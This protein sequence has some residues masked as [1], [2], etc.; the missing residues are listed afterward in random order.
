MFPQKLL[1][2]VF[3]REQINHG[4]N[5]VLLC[6]P[7]NQSLS[8]KDPAEYLKWIVQQPEGPTEKELRARVKSHLVPYEAIMSQGDLAE[9]VREVHSAAGDDGG[10]AHQG[11]VQGLSEVL[12]D[13]QPG[14]GVGESS[15]ALVPVRERGWSSGIN[16][17]LRDCVR[18]CELQGCGLGGHV[19]EARAGPLFQKGARV[20][21]GLKIGRRTRESLRFRTVG[22]G[23]RIPVVR[24]VGIQQRGSTHCCEGAGPELAGCGN[25]G[26][27]G[28][29]SRGL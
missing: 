26:E 20:V 2:G 15:Y 13:D 6:K 7:T 4:L 24:T 11:A 23:G 17:H 21:K 25:Q 18:H 5:G 14:A 28:R 12:R 10:Q 19:L 1:R 29:R 3:K 22:E 8:E 16:E 27:T 9:P